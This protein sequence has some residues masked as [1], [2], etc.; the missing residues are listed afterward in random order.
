MLH[1]QHHVLTMRHLKLNKLF[2]AQ[3]A[4]CLGVL[5]VSGLSA[6]NSQA[7]EVT[8][9]SDN[10]NLPTVTL[11][12]ITVTSTHPTYQGG[13]IATANEI[14]FLGSKSVKDTPFNVVGYKDKYVA[15]IQAKDISDVINKTDPSVF[16][17]NDKGSWSENY[18][19][20]GFT[21]EPG[22]M[23][24]NGLIGISPFYRTAPEMYEG[25]Q[26]LKGPSALLNGMPPKG[27]VGGMINLTP[28]RAKSKPLNRLTVD[29]T[30]SANI[31]GHVDIARRFGEKNQ[32]GA[33]FNGVYRDGEGAID[34]QEHQTKLAALGLDGQ[35]SRG[36]IS[37]DIYTSQDHI[38][39]VARGISLR[40]NLKAIPKSPA[41]DKLITPDW[42]HVTNKDKGIMLN[43]DYQLT[44]NLT[45]YAKYGTSRTDYEYNGAAGGTILDNKGNFTTSMGQLTFDIDKKSAEAGIKGSFITGDIR[46][47]W[48]L[49]TTYYNH[50]QNE[51]GLVPRPNWTADQLKNWQ[52]TTNLYHP[53]WGEPLAMSSSLPQFLHRDLTLT[54]YGV[55]DTM[56]MLDGKVELTL[57]VRH[58]Q[59]KD[60]SSSF[61]KKTVY[62]KGATTPAAAI[63]YKA[64]DN[65]SL[66]ANYMEG[67]TQGG[68]APATAVNAGTVFAPQKTKQKEVGLKFDTYG[69]TNTLSAFE[70]EKPNSY[71][72]PTT[73]IYS[74]DG[75]QRNRGIEWSFVGSPLQDIRLMGGLSYLKPELS[76]TAGG[77]NQGNI[78]VGVPKQQA[79]LGVEW[80]TPMAEGLTLTANASHASKQYINTDNSLAIPSR[81]IFDIGGR[82]KTQ[83]GNYPVTLNGVVENVADKKYWGVGQMDSF[84]TVGAPRTF[85]L[86]ASI[87]F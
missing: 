78:A 38:D 32:F 53:N 26:V 58:Q 71:T 20:R 40:S 6:M 7:A 5:T 70:I 21:S 51:Y 43:G 87:D 76:R 84:L 41:S 48:V 46:H 65:L 63:V 74:S 45:G 50:D 1:F 64:N 61:G 69:I 35:F 57:G 85:K 37:A 36:S 42:S 33:R 11:P 15:D 44:N 82:Y 34:N 59:V 80:D 83:I 29:Y 19:I 13:Q 16:S 25:V 77:I 3:R 55:A 79:K 86:S 10:S 62:D 31:G 52:V 30:N 18:Y 2:I 60:E 23:T 72:D 22:D 39:G 28:K 68:A 73:K 27:S 12:T 47:Q 49:N 4:V 54:S 14:G 56:A 8:A 9:S 75:Q 24:V 81:T 17:N 66:Y 67:L